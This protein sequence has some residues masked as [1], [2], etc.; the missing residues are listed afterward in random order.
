[1]WSGGA[2]FMPAPHHNRAPPLR[3]VGDR[4]STAP[5]ATV[6]GWQRLRQKDRSTPGGEA[7]APGG[8][9]ESEF[10]MEGARRSGPDRR[11]S[12]V[13]DR[14]FRRRGSAHRGAVRPQ[15]PRDVSPTLIRVDQQVILRVHDYAVGDH[16]AVDVFLR[17]HRPRIDHLAWPRGRRGRGHRRDQAAPRPG[18]GHRG[19]AERRRAWRS[20]KR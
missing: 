18:R 12:G 13:S 3:R 16:D 19:D 7:C 10:A 6:P 9:V 5:F 11:G 8:A 4:L 15:H 2:S 20:T 1:V 17:R 14:C